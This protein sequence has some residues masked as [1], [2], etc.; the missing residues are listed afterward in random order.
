MPV[1]NPL[2]LDAAAIKKIE[3][4]FSILTAK[5]NK[6]DKKF[7]K[8]ENFL[9]LL[10]DENTP[11]LKFRPEDGSRI[12]LPI[13]GI[14]H[15]DY[16]KEWKEFAVKIDGILEN[17][18]YR[19]GFKTRQ[20]LFLA[21]EPCPDDGHPRI[22]TGILNGQLSVEEADKARSLVIISTG[23]AAHHF[24]GLQLSGDPDQD[25]VVFVY[26]KL[27]T[28]GETAHNYP[29]PVHKITFENSFLEGAGLK[30]AIKASAIMHTKSQDF[31]FLD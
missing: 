24:Y 15:K 28:D 17:A 14:I 21:G 8:V 16:K 30:G 1:L 4:T 29:L 12:L 13:T 9:N 7:Q 19:K 25:D 23:L 2:K 11:S 27:K 6:D 5:A 18:G 22:P 3:S 20:E 31:P 10:V 26:D